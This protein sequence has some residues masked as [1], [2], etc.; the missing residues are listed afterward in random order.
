MSPVTK[1]VSLIAV[2]ADVAEQPPPVGGV[3]VPLV[4]VVRRAVLG[5]QPGDV[6]DGAHEVV[7]QGR[8]VDRRDH[9]RVAD[10]L[11]LRGAGAQAVAEPVEL[12]VA[13]DGPGRVADRG[14]GVRR[15]EGRLLDL[16]VAVGAQV[17]HADLGQLPEL[18]PPEEPGAV[19]EVGG[20]VH[21]DRHPL[22]VRA[23]GAGAA[24]QVVALVLLV[25]LP[26]LLPLVVGDLVVVPG[27]DPGELGVRVLEVG[28][29]LVLRVPLPVVG[30]ADHLAGRD[31][32]PD[33]LVGL[34]VAVLAG[35]VLVEVVTEVQ[36]RV[37]VVAGRDAA[38][39][40]EPAGLPVGAG[41]DPEPEVVGDGVP[42]GRGAGTAGA[43]GLARAAE[44]VEVPLR[45]AEAVDVDLDGVVA[46]RAGLEA[47]PADDV[48]ELAVGGDLPGDG[49]AG[50]A[51][52]AGSAGVG[53]GDAGPEQDRVRLRVTGGDAVPE[54]VAGAGRA[55][56]S[57]GGVGRHEGRT[58]CPGSAGGEDGT[59][60]E[61]LEF[62]AHRQINE[63]PAWVVRVPAV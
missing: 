19:A 50:T 51:A 31:V 16:L 49:D 15:G 56:R 27:D 17:E 6:V 11:P 39:G 36:D 12:A 23:V 55:A 24:A 58:G 54:H 3:A 52:R 1:S 30:E 59:A 53:G 41:D 38:V 10:Q 9:H 63:R 46:V 7:G 48:A 20:A 44:A 60:G 4:D 32:R 21:P 40:A 28:V 5:Q 61:R 35:R 57:G 8:E 13:G 22:V 29:G 33:V 2:V 25:V 45:R 42:G 37:Q 18:Q 43:A 47:A 26:A 62:E 14:V 34:A